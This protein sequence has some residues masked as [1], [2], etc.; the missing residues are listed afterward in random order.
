[1]NTKAILFLLA[2]DSAICAEGN[3]EL[4]TEL[5]ATCY[6]NEHFNVTC[7]FPPQEQL[8]TDNAGQSI[9]K[10]DR[11]GDLVLVSCIYTMY[12]SI[13]IVGMYGNGHVY[14]SSRTQQSG[15]WI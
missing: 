12:I 1:V 2:V 11:G 3:R 6:F 10:N 7:A 5:R 4:L 15:Q 13:C 9:H 14:N 8:N